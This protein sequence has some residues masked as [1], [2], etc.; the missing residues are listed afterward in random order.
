MGFLLFLISFIFSASF[1]G[2]TCIFILFLNSPEFLRYLEFLSLGVYHPFCVQSMYIY[3]NVPLY[4][5][6]YRGTHSSTFLY[7][8]T[9]WETLHDLLPYF[10]LLYYT[11]SCWLYRLHLPWKFII[12][13]GNFLEIYTM[14][15]TGNLMSTVDDL[16]CNSQ[17]CDLSSFP[18]EKNWRSVFLKKRL[19]RMWLILCF[20]QRPVF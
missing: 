17:L 12:Y 4:L 19:P 18:T 9:P 7:S 3:F 1:G 5:I 20:D 2:F 8:Q 14:K 6:G 15:Q 10:W 13:P 11:F 16:L